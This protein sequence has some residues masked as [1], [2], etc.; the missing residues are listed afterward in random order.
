MDDDFSFLKV[1]G[2]DDKLVSIGKII[3]IKIRPFHD[4]R[5]RVK[6]EV[7]R[8]IKN[9]KM[10]KAFQGHRTDS[11]D[12]YTFY[13][14]EDLEDAVAESNCVTNGMTKKDLDDAA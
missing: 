10:A 13:Q 3:G 7:Q 11:T 4:Y 5:K 6:L 2:P 9:L 12:D 14:R 1:K 8:K